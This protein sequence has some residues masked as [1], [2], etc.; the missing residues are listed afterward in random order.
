MLG[1]DVREFPVNTL[2]H[3]G[4]WEKPLRRKNSQRQMGFILKLRDKGREGDR[5]K[6]LRVGYR[7]S[8]STRENQHLRQCM[9]NVDTA[10]IA[11][12]RR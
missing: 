6:S 9:T 10:H 7:L 11:R 3:P 2:L 12:V 1:T 8:K 5:G 4:Q